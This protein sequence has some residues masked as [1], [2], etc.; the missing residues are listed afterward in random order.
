MLKH[1]NIII[2]SSLI[3]TFF[4]C[5]RDDNNTSKNLKVVEYAEIDSIIFNPERGFYA[6]N[7]FSTNNTSSLSE[8]NL[9]FM[10]RNGHSL[11]YTAYTMPEFRDKLIS[12]EFLNRIRVNMSLLREHGVKSILRFRYTTSES[13]RPWDATEEIVMQHIEQIKPILEEYADVIL[14]MEAGF[15]GVWGEWY[16]TDN[17]NYRPAQNV[18]EYAPRRRVLDALLDALPNQRM[19]C[20]RYPAAKL[21]TFGITHTDTITRQTAYNGSDLSRIASH[22]DCFLADQDDRGTFG[23]NRFYRQFWQ[24]ES[25]YLAMGGETCGLSSFSICDNAISDMEKYHWSFLNS[26]YHPNVLGQWNT[27]GCMDQIKKRLGYRFVLSKGEFT[28]Q[29]KISEK[30]EINLHLKNVGFAA[31]FNPRAVELVFVNKTSKN[32]YKIELNDDPRFWFANEDVIIKHT[33]NLPSEMVTGEYTICLNLPD[34][35]P[36]LYDNPLFS[37]RLANKEMWNS[38][39]GYNEL[40]TLNFQ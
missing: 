28:N 16:Y 2:L 36:T 30:F 8:S 23:G 10:V 25:K 34:P 24:K 29:P 37:I 14:V 13:D 20:V 35:E 9:K 12:E 15:I 21:F 27:S 17:F 33:V 22:N 7:D 4:A 3:L 32:E 40:V 39:K 26:S 31:P 19:I 5:E 11:T 18:E 6:F 38:E 1:I